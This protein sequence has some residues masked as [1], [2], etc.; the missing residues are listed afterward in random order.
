[1]TIAE[2]ESLITEA[3]T[4]RLWIRSASNPDLW[5]S[6]AEADAIGPQ[7]L[8]DMMAYGPDHVWEI[9]DPMDYWRAVAMK[10]LEE[11]LVEIESKR[12]SL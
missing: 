7:A 2:I 4:R 9:G 12:G 6:P 1:M 11:E 10:L 5:H 3:R 8:A